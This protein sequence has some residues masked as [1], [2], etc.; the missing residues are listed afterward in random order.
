[1]S[2][3]ELVML[4]LQE[5]MGLTESMELTEQMARMGLMDI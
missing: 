5:Q 1:L 3:P 2:L 4:E